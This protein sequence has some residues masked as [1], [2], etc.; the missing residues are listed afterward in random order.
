MAIPGNNLMKQQLRQQ[1]RALAK[2]A[3]RDPAPVNAA[4]G[5]WIDGRSSL[6]TIATFSALPGE[7]DLTELS[8]ARPGIRWVYPKVI[9]DDLTFHHVRNPAADLV[10]GAFGILEP[11]AELKAAP[12]ESIDAF[13]C[14]GLAF[15]A[16]GG[17]LGRGRGFYDRLLAKARPD[18]L[19]VGVCFPWQMVDDTFPEAHDVVMDAVVF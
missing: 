2:D 14:P 18:A 9:G 16:K 12:V 19:A 7:V 6:H 11:R 10:R 4:L 15:D 17:R 8:A 13:L 5:R 3:P 1:M